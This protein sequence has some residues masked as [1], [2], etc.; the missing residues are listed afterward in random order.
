MFPLLFP[1]G[2]FFGEKTKI[3]GEKNTKNI[4]VHKLFALP[5][6]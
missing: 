2:D 6:R 1:T 4:S 3:F 5:L